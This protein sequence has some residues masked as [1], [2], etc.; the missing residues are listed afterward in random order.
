MLNSSCTVNCFCPAGCSILNWIFPH[1]KCL[2]CPSAGWQCVLYSFVQLS[3]SLSSNK[4]TYLM[5][6]MWWVFC[7]IYMLY[8]EQRWNNWNNEVACP[9]SFCL[10][11]MM[12]K[13]STWGQH[14]TKCYRNFYLD[15]I[16]LNSLSLYTIISVLCGLKSETKSI[17]GFLGVMSMLDWKPHSSM[18]YWKSCLIW[19]VHASKNDRLYTHT[20]FSSVPIRFTS[21]N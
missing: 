9:S 17:T 15:F 7:C 4:C 16:Q 10:M 19:I 11:L 6:T 5:D 12:L 18:I 3:G 13:R 8:I 14:K 20:S 1:A 2:K 21:Y